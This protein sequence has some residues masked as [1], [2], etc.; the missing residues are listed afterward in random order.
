MRK[1]DEAARVKMVHEL[2]ALTPAEKAHIESAQAVPDEP[3][4]GDNFWN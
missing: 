3:V 1:N 4:N 2:Y